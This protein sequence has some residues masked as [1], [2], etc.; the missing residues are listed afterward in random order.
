[1]R[2]VS[3]ATFAALSAALRFTIF[4]VHA[5]ASLASAM[6]APS[7][8]MSASD[9]IAKKR[10]VLVAGAGCLTGRSVCN[11]LRRAPGV[12][13]AALAPEELFLATNDDGRTLAAD[14]R[15]FAGGSVDALV[16][17]TDEAPDA[18]DVASLVAPLRLSG[19]QHVVFYGRIGKPNDALALIGDESKAWAEAETACLENCGDAVATI[20]RTGELKGGPYYRLDVDTMRARKQRRL[21]TRSVA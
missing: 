4:A 12:D 5:P 13:L 2:L 1:M 9:G 7:T 8:V 19:A 10:V 3:L 14:A 11:E 15:P 18:Q 21:W 20:L 6:R 17:A 16:I